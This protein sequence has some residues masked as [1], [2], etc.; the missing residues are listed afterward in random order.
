M[1]VCVGVMWGGGGVRVC[2]NYVFVPFVCWG[3]GCESF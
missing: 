2:C 1:C 3:R